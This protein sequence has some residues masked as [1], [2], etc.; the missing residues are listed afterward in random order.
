[1]LTSE[2]AREAKMKYVLLPWRPGNSSPNSR[3]PEIRFADA[4]S[5]TGGRLAGMVAAGGRSS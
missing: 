2:Q 4:F 3:R 1:M 5:K